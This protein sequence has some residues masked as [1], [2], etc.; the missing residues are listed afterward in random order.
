MRA[1][2]GFVRVV[3]AHTPAGGLLLPR[4]FGLVDDLAVAPGARHAGIASELV[5]AAEVWAR[6]R[7]LPALEVTAWAFNVPAQRLYA[8]QG[9]TVLRHY[10]RKPLASE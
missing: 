2:V 8:K 5:H 3:E 1:V 7:R 4:R 9:F 10:L 6:E